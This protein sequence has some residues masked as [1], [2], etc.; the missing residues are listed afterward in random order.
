[1]KFIAGTGLLLLIGFTTSPNGV[2]GE[3]IETEYFPQRH[4]HLK[5]K[6]KTPSISRANPQDDKIVA[7]I[8][9]VELRLK[10]PSS[11]YSPTSQVSIYLVL[12]AQ[13]AGMRD[14][15]GFEVSWKTRK[16]FRAGT[17]RPGDRVL[18]Y[19]GTVNSAVL[20][21]F[22]TFTMTINSAEMIGAISFEPYYE[23]ERR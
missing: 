15:R 19:Q 12:P 11:Y 4:F 3:R 8:N 22:V 21:D 14:S 6:W 23:I 9:Q 20:S 1:M 18:F 2:A 5:G 10:I 17:A 13:V 16:V 7:T